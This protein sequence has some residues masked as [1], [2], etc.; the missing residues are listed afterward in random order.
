MT[1]DAPPLHD[2]ACV[3]HVHSRHSDGSGTVR[4]IVAAAKDA[5]AD[6]VLLTDHDTLAARDAG[7]ERWHG[8]VLVCVG[9]EVT[10]RPGHHYLAFGIDAP[11]DHRGLA[12]RQV[13]AEVARRGGFGLLAHPF[14]GMD[15]RWGFIPAAGWHE[16]APPGAVGFELWSLFGDTVESIGIRDFL[17][18]V[19]NPDRVLDH[20]RP[21]ALAALDRLAARRRITAIGGL[22][23]HQIGLRIGPWV[24]LRPLSYRRSFRLLRTHVLLETPPSGDGP[25]DR[26]AIYAALL[27]GRAYVARDS[28]APASGFSFWAERPS[29]AGP[30]GAQTARVDMGAEAPF[31]AG[32]TLHVRLPRAASVRVL[33]AGTPVAEA[34]TTAL[35]VPA[36]APGA[37][38]VEARLLAHGRARTWILS[39]PVYLR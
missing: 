19:R 31:A 26:D 38:R 39:N 25:R 6:V 5:G 13:V 7:E 14:S 1:I 27:A 9:E 22:D 10:Q 18:F 36:D 34:E 16:V 15:R 24:L 29:A 11:I 30:A 2:L 21:Q 37:Y 17:R 20:P 8:S 28:L 12:P 4:Q 23:A 33:R 32:T 35:D 3:V